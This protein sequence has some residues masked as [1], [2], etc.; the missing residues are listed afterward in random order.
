MS[1]LSTLPTFDRGRSSQASMFEPEL[2]EA[3]LEIDHTLELKGL[4]SHL[5]G[6][7]VALD[8]LR[9]RALAVAGSIVR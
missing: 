6:D 4:L 3:V 9:A 5:C 7:P 1:V 8:D 2:R